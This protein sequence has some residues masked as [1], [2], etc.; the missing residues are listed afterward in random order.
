MHH[1]SLQYR[2]ISGRASNTE[3]EESTFNSLKTFTKHTSNH[4][5]SNI[6]LNALVRF[7]S[8]ESNVSSLGISKLMMN[9]FDINTT[10]P[11]TSNEAL[12]STPSR[13]KVEELKPA[14]S[15]IKPNITS[16]PAPSLIF[17]V[18]AHML[19]IVRDIS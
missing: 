3:K 19:T 10:I 13:S 12:N 9:S 15:S 2:I 8:C 17:F 6:I 16:T 7:Q 5:P 1:A 11:S 14:F 4:H 18:S